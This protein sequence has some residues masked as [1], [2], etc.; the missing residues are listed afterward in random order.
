MSSSALSGHTGQL[1]HNTALYLQCSFC[2]EISSP[3]Y[4]HS[5]FIFSRSLL[6]CYFTDYFPVYFLTIL[7]LQPT[8]FPH[9]TLSLFSALLFPRILSP[10]N[11]LFYF[12]LLL[13]FFVCLIYFAF[14][15]D[16]Q[17]ILT[18]S[19]VG[20]EQVQGTGFRILQTWI[21]VLFGS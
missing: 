6:I 17:L 2:R 7:E 16:P 8:L 19:Q 20:K 14:P 3:G 15:Q 4:P 13:L 9:S 11:I 12:V 21:P 5:P 18:C 10:Y 1:V